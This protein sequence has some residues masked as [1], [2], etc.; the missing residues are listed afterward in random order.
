MGKKAA[1]DDLFR[2]GLVLCEQ[3]KY[4]LALSLLMEAQLLDPEKP[5]ILA[6]IASLLLQMGRNG[7]AVEYSKRALNRDMTNGL[8]W[9][10]L[11]VIQKAQTAEKKLNAP[12]FLGESNSEILD[13]Y[14][15]GKKFLDRGDLKNALEIFEKILEKDPKSIEAILAK[16]DILTR[17]GALDG[18]IQTMREALETQPQVSEFWLN[19]GVYLERSQAFLAAEDVYRKALRC[20]LNYP[21]ALYNIALLKLR[22]SDSK[23]GWALYEHRLQIKGAVPKRHQG[24]PELKSL[25]AGLGKRVLVWAEQGLGDTIQFVRFLPLLHLAGLKVELEVPVPLVSLIQKNLSITVANNLAKDNNFDFQIS[26]LSIPALLAGH[27]DITAAQTPYLKSSKISVLLGDLDDSG[28]RKVG[29]S[30]SG[31]AKHARDRDRSI[32][33]E[34][35]K[36]ILDLGKVFLIQKEVRDSD[37]AALDYGFV[38]LSEQLDD[39]EDTAAAV[40]QMD[41]IVTVDSSLAHLAGAMGKQ[42]ILLLPFYPDWRWG[43]SGSDSV[44]YPTMTLLRQEKAGEWGPV[45]ERLLELLVSRRA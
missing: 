38:N 29:I 22:L 20:R 17:K 15:A 8:A 19:L 30:C 23:D 5:Q 4:E 18:A 32:A 34:L 40:R 41:L 44:W 33:L 9:K 10:T 21:D 25:G 27:F 24:I 43:V 36:P 35:F 37:Q 6:N 42:V 3:K 39:F 26:L 7:E 12:I 16:A 31:N 2:Q 1:A 14:D 13:L 28:A 11:L 45:F